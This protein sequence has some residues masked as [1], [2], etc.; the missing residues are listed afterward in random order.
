MSKSKHCP[1]NRSEFQ[2][3]Y[4]SIIKLF[5]VRYVHFIF[6]TYQHNAILQLFS[7]I[8][9]MGSAHASSPSRPLCCVNEIPYVDKYISKSSISI[10]TN[11]FTKQAHIV[12]HKHGNNVDIGWYT[13]GALQHMHACAAF[14][15]TRICR[16]NAIEYNNMV[17]CDDGDE[18]Q[19]LSMLRQ[20]P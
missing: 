10:K 3:V 2:Q 18:K 14:T 11:K 15:N 16:Y 19:H 20:Q 13:Y 8:Y 4:Y 17:V 6:P 5:N 7:G 12:H 9:G 1:T